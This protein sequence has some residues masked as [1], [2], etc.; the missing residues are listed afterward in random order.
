MNG[1]GPSGGLLLLSAWLL[2]GNG[3]TGVK[4]TPAI[5]NFGT[6][7][8]ADLDRAWMRGAGCAWMDRKGGP[9]RFVAIDD[10]AMVKMGGQLRML[11]PAA[12]GSAM[13][14]FTHDRWVGDGIAI[15]VVRHGSVEGR[16]ESSIQAA[17][18]IA[19][20]A[21]RASR[22]KGVADS[23]DGAQPISYDGAQ[24]SWIIAISCGH[25]VDMG[26]VSVS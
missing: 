6:I 23:C 26:W 19:T 15:A 17:S 25:P 9:I 20:V 16:G 11:G 1:F 12:D 4:E 3:R 10:Q 8:P 21:G 5:T 14:P 24:R 7:R 13:F 18:L 22:V 2:S